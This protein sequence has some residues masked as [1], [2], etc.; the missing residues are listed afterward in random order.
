M[1]RIGL[2]FLFVGGVVLASGAAHGGRGALI[3][4]GVCAA[5][6]AFMRAIIR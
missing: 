5:F 6:M 4:V 1:R 2:E 3:A